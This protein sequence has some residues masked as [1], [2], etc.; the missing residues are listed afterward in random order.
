MSLNN[1]ISNC[2]F[3]TVGSRREIYDS[4]KSLSCYVNGGL[5]K[6]TK[7]TNYIKSNG[8]GYRT[9]KFPSGEV[10]LDDEQYCIVTCPVNYNIR[11]CAA[12]GSGKTTTVLCRIKYLIDKLVVPTKILLLTFNVEAAQNLRNRIKD[13]V[14]FDININIYTI[15]AYCNYI[16]HKYGRKHNKNYSLSELSIDGLEIMKKYGREI[17][18]QYKYVFFDEFQDVNDA[19]FNIL[20]IFANNGCLLTIVGDD[21]QNVYQWRGT[22]NYYIINFDMLI[23][24]VKTYMITANYRSTKSIVSIANSSIEHNKHRVL[25]KTM[26]AKNMAFDTVPELR[27]YSSKNKQFEFI[28]DH[29]KIF[30]GRAIDMTTSLYYRGVAIT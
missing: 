27:L 13:L 1:R 9:F 16:I 8:K 26:N 3:L 4:C 22:N 14:S 21:N 12:A 17:S 29:I 28:I 6:K 25:N 23:S 18:S 15:D 2:K 11:I 7:F 20:K 30:I 10:T 24:N 19:Q 5:A